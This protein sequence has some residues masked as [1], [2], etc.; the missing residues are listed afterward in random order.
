MRA[1]SAALLCVALAS[2]MSIEA[3]AICACQCIEGVPRTLC[4]TIEEAADNPDRCGARSH[5]GECPPAPPGFEPGLFE[6]PAPGAR[7]CREAR[8][9]DPATGSYSTTARVCD[10]VHASDA[11]G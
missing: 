5:R 11:G 8:L 6:P 2:L 1:F 3:S 7:D 10:T 9:L 4:T